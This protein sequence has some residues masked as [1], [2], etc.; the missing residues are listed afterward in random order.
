[1]NQTSQRPRIVQ[2]CH[3]TAKLVSSTVFYERR[4]PHRLNS[5]KISD[6]TRV[7]RKQRTETLQQARFSSVWQDIVKETNKLAF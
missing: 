5:I 2:A 1:M 4:N 3:S 7:G 6:I